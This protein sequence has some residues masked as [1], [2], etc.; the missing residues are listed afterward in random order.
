M[1]L[2]ESLILKVRNLVQD[3]LK[4]G[5]DIFTYEANSTFT[6]TEDYVS[7]VTAVFLNDS[8]LTVTT[9]YTYNEDTNKLTISSSMT[10]GDTVEIQYTYYEN[11]SDAEIEAYIKAGL[12]HIAVNYKTFEVQDD[13]LNPEPTERESYLIALIASIL[14][15]PDNRSYRLSDMTITVPLGVLPTEEIVRKAIAV[16][17]KNTSGVFSLIDF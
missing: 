15:R 6:L 5:K 3:I 8:E 10:S 13:D 1:A 12:A 16:F 9:N 14:I 2:S 4:E 11:F 7:E 17:K